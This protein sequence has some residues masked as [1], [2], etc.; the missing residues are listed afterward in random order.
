[1]MDT[2]LW[3]LKPRILCVSLADLFARFSFGTSK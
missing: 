1:M 3:S 2:V